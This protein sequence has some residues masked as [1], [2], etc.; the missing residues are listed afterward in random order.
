ML[1]G[2]KA[3][4]CSFVMVRTVDGFDGVRDLFE[5]FPLRNFRSP[6]RLW[7]GDGSADAD[8]SLGVSKEIDDGIR[9]KN[10]ELF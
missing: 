4:H 10:A 2:G 7:F 8:L 9:L 6:L 1:V 5:R 3:S